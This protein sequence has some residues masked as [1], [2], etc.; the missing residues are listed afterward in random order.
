MKGDY[1]RIPFNER[2][3]MQHY[4]KVYLQQG[5][6]LLDSDLNE[7]TDLLHYQM[8]TLA[9]DGLCGSPNIGFRIGRG[10]PLLPVDDHR[11]IDYTGEGKGWSVKNGNGT[12]TINYFEKFE[13][14]GSLKLQNATKDTELS[15]AFQ[16][17]VDLSQYR[18]LRLALKITGANPDLILKR[19]D[20]KN[21]TTIKIETKKE[22]STDQNKFSVIKYTPLDAVLDN[23][24]EICLSGFS[25]T[26]VD[27]LIG[28]VECSPPMFT[29]EL[30]THL[31]GWSF[32]GHAGSANVSI[33]N[34]NG[35]GI[36]ATQ[37]E[38]LYKKHFSTVDFSKFETIEFAIKSSST[39]AIEFYITDKDGNV[40][41]WKIKKLSGKL[42]K[43]KIIL[44]D[45]KDS[46][47]P[48]EL[49]FIKEYG[50]RGLSSKNASYGFGSILYERSLK[51]NFVISGTD[52]LS[53]ETGRLYVDGELYEKEEAETYLNQKDYPYAPL[54]EPPTQGNTRTD[55]VYVDVW[56]RH[57]TSA[58]DPE[59][60]E[61][62][63][64]VDTCNRMKAV[65]QVKVLEGEE[66]LPYDLKP[67]GGG[68]LST[69]VEYMEVEKPCEITSGVEYTGAENRLYRVEIHT[70]GDVGTATYKWSRNNA[71]TVSQIIENVKVNATSVKVKDVKLF[72]KGDVIEITDDRV[73][74]ADRK[75]ISEKSSIKPWGELRR[76]TSIDRDKNELA[77][78]ASETS[79][80]PLPMTRGLP[81]DYI[82]EG[83]ETTHPRVIKWDGAQKTSSEEK[84]EDGIRIRFSG[85][86]M[87]PG[88]YWTFTARENT[89]AVEKLDNEP[90]QGVLHHYYPLA[91]I[92]WDEN[93]EII[94][95]ADL[96]TRFE[97]LCG[98]TAADLAFDNANTPKMFTNSKNVQE[99]LEILDFPNASGIKLENICDFLYGGA[100][101]VQAALGHLCDGITVPSLTLKCDDIAKSR[102]PKLK[103]SDA[104]DILFLTGSPAAE[105]MRILAS[106]YIWMPKESHRNW[107]GVAM[108]SDGEYQTAVVLNGQIYISKDS[109]NTWTAKESPQKWRGV[110]M[111]SDG[112]YQTAVGSSGEI[113]ISNNNGNTWTPKESKRDWRGVAMS[114]DGIY[115][116]AVVWNGKIYISKDSGNTWAPKESKRDWWGVAMSSDGE[117]QTAVVDKGKIYISKDSGNTWAPK[118]SKREWRGVAMSS[119]GKYQTA[120]GLSAE[121]YISSNSG[122]TWAPKESRQKWRGVAMSSDGIYQTAVVWGGQIYISSD[123]GNTWTAKE[124]NRNWRGVAM[125][126]DG[127]YH[128]AVVLGA[129]RGQIYSAK[130]YRLLAKLNVADEFSAYVR[131]AD[132]LIGHSSR[133]GSPGRA[134]V[135]SE[136]VL[137]LNWESDWPEGVRYSGALSQ[138]SSRELKDNIDDLSVQE[139]F[140]A[141]D[142][143][144]PVKFSLKADKE[145]NMQVGF[146]AE[147]APSMVASSDRKAI[148]FNHIV[149]ILTKVIKEQQKKITALSENI[150]ALE[151]KIDK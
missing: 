76:I 88:D 130:N 14:K 125:S 149:G 62:A 50:F 37:T 47:T 4:R 70:G 59:I 100:D 24:T 43:K 127:E 124:I 53:G 123:Y 87:L 79:G 140:E 102:W 34:I 89:R 144:N 10:V 141:L 18:Y 126:S 143:L 84:L 20:G 31:E 105:A 114:S 65:A 129:K 146:I 22:Q 86:D 15:F 113:Y 55:L 138:R 78:V 85:S 101:N 40:S 74:L 25:K 46:G 48:A 1:S 135:D 99:A 112:E 45:G 83:V 103:C 98:L 111:S 16:K 96:R 36:I 13:G 11:Y 29:L 94:N 104:G 136:T 95:I 72:K 133:R 147:G 7:N 3:K 122:N 108:S 150:K 30:M 110:A 17:P 56:Q 8:K 119:D 91:E 68:R 139:A 60:R 134:L 9:K 115:Q 39:S 137:D 145:K 21:Q 69:V 38:K 32:E 5:K 26:T 131:C 6:V 12:L 117:Y 116:T 23:I 151:K 75:Y 33:E 35:G 120:V 49:A 61:V 52:P 58:E 54:M 57:V 109:G 80:D 107:W 73:E 93:G 71:S 81:H 28:A 77:W 63:V 66:F 128:T 42:E 51:N 19:F 142:D 118:E 44:P 82:A 148:F 106:Q 67:T 97:P 41:Y 27:L 2:K 121:I 64:G 132:F 92:T 90:P